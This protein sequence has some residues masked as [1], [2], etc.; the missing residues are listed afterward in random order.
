LVLNHVVLER[1]AVEFVLP[2][3]VPH[4]SQPVAFV[5]YIRTA[6][7]F[8]YILLEPQKVV[9]VFALKVANLYDRSLALCAYQV[10]V[11]EGHL[12]LRQNLQVKFGPGN[13]TIVLYAFF[14]F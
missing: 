7:H 10:R 5:P 3:A 11:L 14:D 2:E 6:G 8:V 1:P 9:L 4:V 13:H 12:V